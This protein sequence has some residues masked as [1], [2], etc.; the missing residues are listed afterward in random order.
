M[1]GRNSHADKAHARSPAAA[2]RAK[3]PGN[4]PGSLIM[5]ILFDDRPAPAHHTCLSQGFDIGR[6][7]RPVL[8]SM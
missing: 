2:G 6:S 8:G 1:M 3:S 5:I 4:G 7:V